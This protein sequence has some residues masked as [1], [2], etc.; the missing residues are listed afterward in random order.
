VFASTHYEDEE[1][2][3]SLESQNETLSTFTERLHLKGPHFVVYDGTTPSALGVLTPL[4]LNKPFNLEIMYEL[5]ERHLPWGESRLGKALVEQLD[6]EMEKWEKSLHEEQKV[7]DA[8]KDRIK[9]A[10]GPW[11][12]NLLKQREEVGRRMEIIRIRTARREQLQE[13]G[14]R[15]LERKKVDFPPNIV[16]SYC[17]I[18]RG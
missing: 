8:L 17:S 10:D 2:H 6:K 12:R 14:E 16:D 13:R 9:K 1:G 7:K 4:L 18:D 15:Q 11:L 5:A 3:E